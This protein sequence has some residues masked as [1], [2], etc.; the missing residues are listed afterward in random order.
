M[1]DDRTGGP[2]TMTLASPNDAAQV[3]ADDGGHRRSR[4]PRPADVAMYGLFVLACA[5]TL[6]FAREV[7]MPVVV[8]MLLFLLFWPVVRTMTRARIP[9]PV[10]A[11]VLVL[12]LLGGVTTAVYFLA[13]PAAQW[14]AQMPTFL[15]QIQKQ[16]KEPVSEIQQ[17]QDTVE[18]LIEP[19]A[20][21]PKLR[22]DAPAPE[23]F[24]RVSLVSVFSTVALAVRDVGWAIVVIF[25]LLYFLLI[26]GELQETK[27]VGMFPTDRGKTRARAVIER[28]YRDISGYLL[29]VTLINAGLGICVGVAVHLAGLPNAAL[30]GVMAAFLN[31]IPYL[32]PLIGVGVVTIV[33]LLTFENSTD[34]ILPPLIYFTINA[35]EGQVVTPW[36]LG[37]R[38][39]L[40][41]VAVFISV[42]F[43]GWLWGA[44]G[45]ILAVPLLASV[46]VICGGVPGWRTVADLIDGR[47]RTRS[48]P[49]VPA[50]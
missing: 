19:Q 44:P 35:I 18:K 25:T 32:G 6:Y 39:T 10:G 20:A 40:N 43:W 12:G 27:L 8:A 2:A 24:L 48:G 13:D 41:P 23:S 45:V 49:P 11:A 31:F 9:A 3:P 5:Y 37:Q 29:T 33:G 21:K 17:M 38:L 34:A 36:L 50:A 42:V 7:L 47:P 46:K 26:S 15:Q 1:A 4:R 16:V 30:W 14:M 22:R 28:V